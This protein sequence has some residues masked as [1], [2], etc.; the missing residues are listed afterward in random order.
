MRYFRLIFVFIHA[1]FNNE[2]AFR[3]NFFL[4]ILSV[5]LSLLGGMGGIYIIYANN[6]SI[7]GWT[8]PETLAVLGVFM[9]V[10]AISG[11][12]INPSLNT[13]GGMGGELETGTFDYTMLRPIS[14]QYYISLR[15]WSL[16]QFL[17]IGVSIGVIAVAASMMDITLNGISLLLFLFSILVSTGILYSILLFVNSVAFWYRGTYLSW[18]VADILQTGRYPIG[19]YPNRLRFFLTW[20]FPIGFIVS[21]PAEAI[22]GKLQPTLLPAGFVLMIVMF[23]LSSAFFRISI[24]KY[25]GASS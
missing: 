3:M 12:F 17:H 13:L 23:V 8:M 15:E 5:V 20:L 4:N 21:V 19:I 24:R 11:L 1:A 2:A 16:W 6:E 25:S 7:R 22:T 9:L 14:K 10:Q 18:I